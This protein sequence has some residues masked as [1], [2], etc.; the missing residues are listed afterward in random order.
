MKILRVTAHDFGRLSGALDLAPGLTVIHGPNE[1]GKSTWLQAIFAGLCGRRRGRGSNTL[2]ERQFRQQYEPWNGRPWR[3]TVKLQLDDGRRIEIQQRDLTAKESTALDDHTGRPIGDEL[4]Y[5][6]SI[7]GSRFLGLN[8]QVMPSTLV[9]AQGDIQRLRQKGGDE[10]S[11]LRE[12]L[13][14]AAASVGGAATAVEALSRLKDYARE[15][16]GSERRNSTRP[17]QRAVERLGRA[18]EDLRAGRTRHRERS[19]LEAGLR[20]ARVRAERANGV[21]QHCTRVLRQREAAEIESRLAEV[22]RLAA[23]FPDG[24]PP[25]PPGDDPDAATAQELREAAF[26]YRRRPAP[27]ADLDGPSAD[28]MA[29]ELAELPEAPRGDSEPAPEVAAATE[30][31]R[32]ACQT[33]AVRERLGPGE[34]PDTRVRSVD[35]PTARRALAILE[36]P[37]LEPLDDVEQR[38]LELTEEETHYRSELEASS[39]FGKWPWW[40]ATAGS[41]IGVLTMMD[42][43]PRPV[44]IAGLFLMLVCSLLILRAQRRTPAPPPAP[45]FLEGAEENMKVADAKADLRDLKRSHK[46][47]RLQMEAAARDLAALDL[48]ADAKAVRDALE[49][50]GRRERWEAEQESWQQRL[51]DARQDEAAAEQA[52]RTALASRGMDDP[53]TATADLL[54]RYEGDCRH[55]QALAAGAGPREALTARIEARRQREDTAAQQHEERE[56]AEDRWR[57]ALAAAGLPADSAADPEQWADDWLGAHEERIS[58]QR[59]DWERLQ[60]LL[61]GRTRDDLA[62]EHQATARRLAAVADAGP[63]PVELESLGRRALEQRLAEARREAAEAGNR[64]SHLEGQLA[65]ESGLPSLAE[66]EEERAAAGREVDLLRRAAALL[67]KT[68]E[69]LEAAQDEVH[70]LL[71]PDLRDALS[72]RLHQVTA[73]RYSEARI[74]PEEGLEV[75]LRVADGSY[76]AAA[77]LSHGTVDQVYLLLRIALAEA[78]GDRTEAAPLFLDDATVHCDT[79]RTM[80]LLELLLSLSEERQIVVFSQEEEVRAW[81]AERLAAHPRHRLVEL[82]ANGLPAA[83]ENDVGDTTP[84]PDTARSTGEPERQHSLI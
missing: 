74:D 34:P 65:A 53:E 26:A 79:E 48:E 63:A 39:G 41:L 17:L 68:E 75:R 2:E 15:Q 22:D 13:Q 19:G 37:P 49:G 77:E 80:R 57:D 52:L 8:R 25:S 21:T 33:R 46:T 64:A 54:D 12:E 43:L 6:G 83:D 35:A 9:I 59:A 23:A 32:E 42:L 5:R 14:R 3:A 20:A 62:A 18:D 50:L 28:E 45:G 4:I 67:D 81:A 51:A 7:D 66:L 72:R 69:H 38:V 30:G 82:A 71:A 36:L 78:L 55:N 10:A 1:A 56:A 61:D 31:W 29:R 11:A 24:A 44:G 40:G 58:R 70:R 60:V 16:V 27:P 47:R 84:A 76:R 73:G